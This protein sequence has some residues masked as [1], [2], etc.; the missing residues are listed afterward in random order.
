MNRHKK[1]TTVR[2][3]HRDEESQRIW[4]SAQVAISAIMGFVLLFFLGNG[5]LALVH[6][7]MMM[8][9]IH[10]YEDRELE[11]V[12]YRTGPGGSSEDPMR[13]KGILHPEGVEIQTDD[14][15]VSLMQFSPSSSVIKIAPTE[16]AV[17]GKRIKVR[18]YVGKPEDVR[19]W[20]PEIHN[21]FPPSDANLLR[22]KYLTVASLLAVV[23]CFYFSYRANGRYKRL[24]GDE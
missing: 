22:T 10:Q 18:Y 3:P 17:V 23:S 6:H 5:C 2:R 14:Q 16:D 20:T 7:Y 1:T 8:A 19:W 11:I 21:R 9:T 12:S 4:L 13:I 15:A 24:T